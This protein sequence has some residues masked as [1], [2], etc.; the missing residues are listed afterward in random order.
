MPFD[1]NK[2]FDMFNGIVLGEDGAG[3]FGGRGSP[4]GQAA[5][6]GSYYIDADT[7]LMWYKHGALDT[8]W[9]QVRPEFFQDHLVLF[10]SFKTGSSF[11]KNTWERLCVGHLE[12]EVDE[13]NNTIWTFVVICS[14]SGNSSVDIRLWDGTNSQ[15]LGTTINFT[16]KV[17]TFKTISFT[18]PVGDVIIEIQGMKN[19]NSV[20]ELF[21][22]AIEVR[23]NDL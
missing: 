6:Q 20:G 19:G 22:G 15:Q 23:R 3:L 9:R 4:S 14:Q 18:P 1:S 12:G 11:N 5:P 2:A 8:E 21:W 7:G 16:E 13:P 10:T 17:P